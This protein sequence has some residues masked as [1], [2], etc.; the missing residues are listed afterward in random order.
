M[1][2]AVPKRPYRALPEN[3]K[4]C[5][6][7][8]GGYSLALL[9]AFLALRIMEFTCILLTNA[10]LPDIGY[11]VVRAFLNDVTSFPVILFVL[12]VPF[13]I[14]YLST[15]AMKIRYWLWSI[16]GLI[17]ILLYATLIKYFANE[18]VPLG[19][20]L[21][22]YSIDEIH[23]TIRNGVTFNTASIV[24]LILPTIVFW[25]SFSLL[26]SHKL[27]KPGYVFILFGTI[28]LLA[29]TAFVLPARAS[30]KTELSQNL[31]L[32]K[33]VYFVE[34]SCS[35]LTRSLME[36]EIEHDLQNDD[37]P[38][39]KNID[40]EY[41]FLRVDKTPDVL[42]DFLNM[43][44]NGLP[45]IV[46]ILVEGLGRSFSGPGARLESFTPF[47]DELSAKSLYWE[48]FLATQG[49][50]FGA[51]P[52]ILGSLPYAEKG[53]TNLGE[54]MPNSL[55]LLHILKHGGYRIKYYMSSD[56][57]FDNEGLFLQRQGVDVM[58]SLNDFGTE[59]QKGPG[60][61]W[62]FPDRELIRKTLKMEK[63]DQNQPYVSFIQ[64]ISMH[65]R[66]SVPD[67]VKYIHRFEERMTR[68]GLN[69]TQKQE[70]RFYANIYST[71]MYTDDALRLFFQEYAKLP[72][73]QNTIFIIT[74]DH[75]LPEIPMITKI[76]RYHVPLIIF[77]PLLKHAANIR[78]ISSHLD[79][80]PSLLA[81][82]YQN[83]SLEIPV[84]VTWVGT[85]LD[86][87]PAFRNIHSYPLKHTKGLLVDYL[88]GIYFINNENLFQVMENMDLKPIQDEIKRKQL[89]WEFDQYKKRNDRLIRE[90]KLIPDSLYMRF[91][92]T[93]ETESG[94]NHK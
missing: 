73:Y 62:N 66:Y 45:N 20:D 59:Y 79:I 70:Y 24:L 84:L 81:Y 61:D 78:S 41:P 77:S 89:I 47:L 46:F 23:E 19:A 21:Y 36:S 37:V 64:T 49:R 55:S 38:T 58:V 72:T 67:Q 12:F 50:T 63:H 4:N 31:A 1:N 54:R 93:S 44:P 75:R 26:Y 5:T 87:E 53:F 86:T 3:L 83:Y 30:Y 92:K 65:S 51:L 9:F 7:I 11:V 16:S 32:N 76:E 68:L 28:I 43:S 42:S 14:V 8:F 6:I 69:E 27:K 80:T 48:N 60:I 91:A 22:G 33:A 10:P 18:L 71:I 29:C 82:L 88:S 25:G 94:K 13:A 56:Q 57:E 40:P 35:Y 2:E 85:G 17:I 15:G 34:E 74:G 90:L 52:S 39:F